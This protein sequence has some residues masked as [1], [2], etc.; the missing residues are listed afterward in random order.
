MLLVRNSAAG[1]TAKA[2]AKA[3]K[4]QQRGGGGGAAAAAGYYESEQMPANHL[5][6]GQHA[7]SSRQ[8][9]R[10]TRKVLW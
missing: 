2:K 3:G 8:Q 5:I 1:Q 7:L 6:P 10:R 9:K 4:Q